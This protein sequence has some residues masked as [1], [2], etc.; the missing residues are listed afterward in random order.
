MRARTAVDRTRQAQTGWQQNAS[1]RPKAMSQD[2][3]VIAWEN[4]KNVARKFAAQNPVS[5]PAP[6]RRPP[7]R[8]ANV[9]LWADWLHNA[10]AQAA[11]T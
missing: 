1:Q 11:S 7:A 10:S 8:E 4:G 3:R 5:E 9:I 2:T 6:A